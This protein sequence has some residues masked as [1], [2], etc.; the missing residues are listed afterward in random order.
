MKL[1]KPEKTVHEGH[2]EKTDAQ[3]R[4]V[5]PEH[6]EAPEEPEMMEDPVHVARLAQEAKTVNPESL[7]M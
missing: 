7:A 4:P 1:E 2:P 6:E 3:D 5:C